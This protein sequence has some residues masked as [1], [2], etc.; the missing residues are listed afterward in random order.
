MEQDIKRLP[1]TVNPKGTAIPGLTASLVNR[2][3][4]AAW[5]QRSDKYHEV[6]IIK[7]GRTFDG[8]GIMEYYPSNNDFGIS[9]WCIRDPDQAARKFAELTSGSSINERS[10]VDTNKDTSQPKMHFPLILTTT[11]RSKLTTRFPL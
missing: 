11:F 6:F 4:K 10:G 3:D 7:I 1:V 5:Y 9:A 8:S 2:T